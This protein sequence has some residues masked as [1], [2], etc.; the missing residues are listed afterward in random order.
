M[1]RIFLSFQDSLVAKNSQLASVAEQNLNWVSRASNGQKDQ[2]ADL[3]K[4]AL[5][6]FGSDLSNQGATQASGFKSANPSPTRS[7]VN[8]AFDRKLAP[9]RWDSLLD[10]NFR[11]AHKDVHD[12]FKR[13]QDVLL[14]KEIQECAVCFGTADTV[15][16]PCEHRNICWECAFKLKDCPMCRAKICQRYREPTATKGGASSSSSGSG[17]SNWSNSRPSQHSRRG[18]RERRYTK[19]LFSGG[20]R[21]SSSR[22]RGR[23]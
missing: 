20:L 3:R 4:W 8:A 14:A 10:L 7:D 9:G 23:R 1:T 13:A 11:A 18:S 17:G 19:P 5:E 6:I 15:L 2:R 21:R 12:V 16:Y 22:K